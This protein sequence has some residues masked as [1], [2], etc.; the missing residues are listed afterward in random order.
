MACCSLVEDT[1]DNAPFQSTAL[2]PCIHSHDQV[3]SKQA[4]LQCLGWRLEGAGN[5][6][7]RSGLVFRYG[8]LFCLTLARLSQEQDSSTEGI[9]ELAPT[10]TTSASCCS[11]A[12]DKCCVT[13]QFDV[14]AKGASVGASEAKDICFRS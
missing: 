3:Q 4:L 1:E 2:R 6:S 14:I 5:A 9:L 8:H 12:A 13:C 10:G 7:L 11:L